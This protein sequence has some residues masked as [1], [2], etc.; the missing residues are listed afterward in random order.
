MIK[1]LSKAI[2]ALI[3]SLSAKPV[4]TLMAI[5]IVFAMYIGVRSYSTLQSLVV[6]PDQE[7]ARFESQ[8]HAT[9]IINKSIEDLRASTKADNVII[10]QFHNG[11]HDLTGIP[12]TSISTTY[13]V[14]PLDDDG[15]EPSVD[16]P[17][18]SMNKSLRQV[19]QRIDRPECIV[20]Y[21]P[22]D[23]STRRYFRAHNLNRSVVCPLVNLLNYPI[24]V[25]QVGFSQ[26]STVSDEEVE[27]QTS[28][29]SKRVTGYLSNGY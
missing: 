13:Y 15:H 28:L 18:S 4:A 17:I 23:V 11:R 21:S 19:W 5:F 27:K 25:M 29:L 8:L 2:K 16:E 1:D 9:D 26:S 24:G 6:T 22:V 3:D 12:F 10:R 7:A 14:D 20:L